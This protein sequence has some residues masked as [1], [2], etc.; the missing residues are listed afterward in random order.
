VTVLTRFDAPSLRPPFGRAKFHAVRA[1]ALPAQEIDRI[2]RHHAVG[3]AAIRHDVAA[4]LQR[5]QAFP[6]VCER[7]GHRT[8][9]VRRHVLLARPDIDECDLAG[10][11]TPHE[12]VIAHR[13]QRTAFFQILARDVLGF[14]QPGL[15]QASQLEKQ[16]TD[17]RVCKPTCHVQARLVC[18]D[19]TR[20]SEHLQMVR[21]RCDTLTGLIGE[22]FDRPG[23]L[24]E[25]IEELE[26]V[27]A[28]RGLAN[29]RDLFVDRGLGD[30]GRVSV[31]MDQILKCILE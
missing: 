13:L 20:A 21:G 28:C 10:A 22:R 8:R 26:T 31:G 11:D 7:H 9:K 25:E 27:R 4:F 19:Q 12:F 29:P 15:R 2:E 16:R 30:E 18:L 23:S 17:V 6:E 24:G 1:E 14:C 3:P 5:A